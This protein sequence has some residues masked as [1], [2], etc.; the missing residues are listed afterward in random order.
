MWIDRQIKDQVNRCVQSRP[1]VLL[2]GARQTGKSTLLQHMFP[3]THYVTFDHLQ[4]VEAARE[5]QWHDH[6]HKGS[7]WENLVLM[8]LIK[9][10][11]LDP[12]KDLFFYRDQNGVEIDFIIEKNDR[13]ILV[14]A[15]AGE[16]DVAAPTVYVHKPAAYKSGRC[17]CRHLGTSLKASEVKRPGAVG[18]NLKN[19]AEH[20]SVSRTAVREALRR[21]K[22]IILKAPLTGT[23][24][25][26]NIP[27]SFWH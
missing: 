10:M 17:D 25:S 2:T 23:V 19:R 12:G 11:D 7:L 16:R 15:K 13:L 27:P 9:T 18:N 1:A 6:P 26:K 5:A 8:E 3:D 21:R 4:Q 24:P 22:S 14:E 20:L